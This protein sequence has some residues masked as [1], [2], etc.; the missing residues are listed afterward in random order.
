[1]VLAVLIT[2]GI[3]AYYVYINRS[4][5]DSADVRC[6]IRLTIETKSGAQIVKLTPQ[7]N[8]LSEAKFDPGTRIQAIQ[9]EGCG[10]RP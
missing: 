4:A 6:V 2:A 8:T 1:L 9:I 5:S 10:G 3:A 7:D